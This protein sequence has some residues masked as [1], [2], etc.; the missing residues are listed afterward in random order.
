LTKE[1]LPPVALGVSRG[2]KSEHLRGDETSL[3]WESCRHCSREDDDGGVDDFDVVDDLD[4]AVDLRRL[5]DGPFEGNG[6]AEDGGGDGGIKS[7]IHP[8]ALDEILHTKACP[9]AAAVTARV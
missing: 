8:Y 6:K 4:N 5:S 2:A 9:C 7:R 1:Q 3:D